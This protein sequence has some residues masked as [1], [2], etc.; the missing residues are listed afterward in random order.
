MTRRLAG[1]INYE[2]ARRAVSEA[3]QRLADRAKFH[4]YLP[5]LAARSVQ[6]SLETEDGGNS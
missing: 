6:R 5:I 2:T 3:Y 4:N 1:K